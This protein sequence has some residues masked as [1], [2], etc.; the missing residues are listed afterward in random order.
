M[1][2]A[3][4]D[5]SVVVVEVKVDEVGHRTVLVGAV[6]VE[7]YRWWCW[8]YFSLAQSCSGAEIIFHMTIQ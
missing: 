7:K 6:E 3:S 5:S 4:A 1:L 8:F 2:E